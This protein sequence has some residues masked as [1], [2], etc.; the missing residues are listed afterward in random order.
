ML[1]GLIKVFKLLLT[2]K[3]PYTRV[4]R[5]YVVLTVIYLIIIIWAFVTGEATV[6]DFAVFG[7]IGLFGVA[8]VTFGGFILVKRLRRKRAS[9][10]KITTEIMQN[11]AE[12]RAAKYGH[13]K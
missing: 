11:R 4:W 3:S 12:R 13:N 8:Y 9:Q 10:A 5:I 1:K 6:A 7:S 2:D